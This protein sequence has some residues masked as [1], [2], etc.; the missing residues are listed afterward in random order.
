M[1]EVFEAARATTEAD[2]LVVN[3]AT[4]NTVDAV[5]HSVANFVVCVANFLNSRKMSVG[6]QRA[7]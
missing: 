1:R 2:C 5:E 3:A 7:G 6:E 4:T